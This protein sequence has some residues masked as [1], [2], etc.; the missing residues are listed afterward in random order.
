MSWAAA[1]IENG[2]LR[3]PKTNMKQCTYCG[4]EYPDGTTICALDSEPLKPVAAR[5]T[6]HAGKKTANQQSA[7]KAMHTVHQALG[8]ALTLIGAA[9]LV[10]G[11]FSWVSLGAASP[12]LIGRG[13]GLLG[14]GLL[15]SRKARKLSAPK[16][17]E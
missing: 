16:K 2:E 9:N 7:E 4:K 3:I 13:A 14:I 12:H 11:V 17:N 10:L 15:L 1:R 8:A 5:G 6:D